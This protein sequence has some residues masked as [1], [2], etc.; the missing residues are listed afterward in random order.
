MAGTKAT[1][2]KQEALTLVG[3]L[4]D[5]IEIEDLIERLYLRAK[6]L[7]AEA[8]I[9]AGRTVKAERVRKEAAGWH[10]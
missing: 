2:K 5:E 8:D 4:P 7:S 3:Q 9:A 10:G 1:I 6:V